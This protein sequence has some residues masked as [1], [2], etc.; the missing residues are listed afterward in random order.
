MVASAALATMG[1]ADQDRL[2]DRLPDLR[3]DPACYGDHAR[4]TLSPSEAAFLRYEG[5]RGQIG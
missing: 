2:F 5:G 4:R 1:Q 3:G